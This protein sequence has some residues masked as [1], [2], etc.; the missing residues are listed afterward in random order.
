[1]CL[2]YYV[3]KDGLVHYIKSNS[4]YIYSTSVGFIYID[5]QPQQNVGHLMQCDT[6][7]IITNFV[8]AVPSA[9]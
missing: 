1:M 3:K 9:T 8:A 7:R 2:L 4:L 6:I 5:A